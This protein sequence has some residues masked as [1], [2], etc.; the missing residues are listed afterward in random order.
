M[1]LLCWIG[2]HRYFHN[3]KEKRIGNRIIKVVLN[4]KCRGCGK[5]KEY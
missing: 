3:L 5:E 1:K 4:I 2:I